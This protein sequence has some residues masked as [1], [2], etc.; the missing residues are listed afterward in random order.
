MISESEISTQCV[1]KNMKVDVIFAKAQLLYVSAQLYTTADIDLYLSYISQFTS[2]VISKTVPLHKLS[3]RS[4]LWW[5]EKIY[6][7]VNSAHQLC[8]QAERF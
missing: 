2:D 4:A 3:D 7:A 6:Q 8:W 1:W 5:S